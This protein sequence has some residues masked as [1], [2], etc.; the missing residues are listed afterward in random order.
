MVIPE[1]INHR[2]RVV[3]SSLLTVMSD[4]ER[5]QALFVLL[6]SH[7]EAEEHFVASR[8]AEL[9][10]QSGRLSAEERMPFTRALMQNMRLGYEQLLRYPDHLVQPTLNGQL[11][12]AQPLAASA[13]Q[14]RTGNTQTHTP[15]PGSPSIAEAVRP[16]TAVFRRVLGGLL[17]PL[18]S[19]AGLGEIMVEIALQ[20]EH[21]GLVRPILQPW[22]QAGLTV[23]A[24]AGNLSQ[25]QMHG[26][27]NV[28]YLT[29]C[30]LLGP[31][32]ADRL[33]SATVSEAKRLPEAR[34]YPP[35]RLL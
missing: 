18:R 16:A 19:T 15:A 14:P 4:A 22:S 1:Q 2:R 24:M 29:A 11:V 13:P 6:N 21:R 3:Y 25:Q 31:V 28:L 33:L 20:T 23:E 10:S 7:L 27:V 17:E 12:N 26:I 9:A 32:E 8:V 35:E 5:A 30:D 34:E